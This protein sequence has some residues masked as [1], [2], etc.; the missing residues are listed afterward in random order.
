MPTIKLA[1]RGKFPPGH[2]IEFEQIIFP[3]EDVCEVCMP[4]APDENSNSKKR[5][6]C[7][8][9]T[10]SFS[11]GDTFLLVSLKI[12]EEYKPKED[13]ARFVGVN[14]VKTVRINKQ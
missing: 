11:P 10:H 1:T 13:N 6:R 5:L 2:L 8:I 14:K 9:K 3:K 4:E 12:L 7:K